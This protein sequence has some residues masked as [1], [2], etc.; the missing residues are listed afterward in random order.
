MRENMVTVPRPRP[1]ITTGW[2]GFGGAGVLEPGPDGVDGL[3][4]I[5]STGGVNNYALVT[6]SLAG[7]AQSVYA[8]VRVR[9]SVGMTVDYAVIAAMSGGSMA[10]SVEL[11]SVQLVAGEWA[12]VAGELF[13]PGDFDSVLVGV[14][15]VSLGLPE[16]ETLDVTMAYVSTSPGDYF[17]G[18]TPNDLDEVGRGLVYEWTG[19]A[20]ESTS[21]ERYGFAGLLSAT[22]NPALGA[23]HLVVDPG[24]WPEQTVQ[25]IRIERTSAS[26]GTVPVR[27]IENLPAPGGGYVGTDHEA[28]INETVQY[29]V[30]GYDAAGQMVDSSTAV[31]KPEVGSCTLYVK[32]PGRPDM[33]MT[34]KFTGRDRLGSATRGGVYQIAGGGAV[35][36]DGGADTTTATITVRTQTAGEARGLEGLLATARTILIQHGG[37]PEIRPGWWFVSSWE[38]ANPAG[39]SFDVFSKRDYQLTL[40][41]TQRPAG[42]GVQFTGTTWGALIASHNTW[43][44]VIDAYPTWLDVILGEG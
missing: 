5:T 10:V 31:V 15:N 8:T 19:A 39:K 38:Q 16:G 1:G 14:G 13:V 23:V 33:T 42:V 12:E 18:A 9:A 6:P 3:Y 43:Q 28:P 21:T 11:E 24:M 25:R 35:A 17:D 22:W 32:A 26:E 34:P 20:W 41:A 37:E 44:D 30:Y 27:G 29:T 36:Q 7:S 40:Q 4:R 2:S